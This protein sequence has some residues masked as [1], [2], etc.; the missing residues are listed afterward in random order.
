[1]SYIR[2]GDD[3][4]THEK[5]HARV[6]RGIIWDG[7]GRGKRVKSKV[8]GDKGWRVIKDNVPINGKGRGRILVVD[9]S[10][11]GVKVCPLKIPDR[12]TRLIEVGRYP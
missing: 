5:H 6:T 4:G 11:G 3:E 2:G 9:G 7:L 10:Y 12:G 1:M 8:D